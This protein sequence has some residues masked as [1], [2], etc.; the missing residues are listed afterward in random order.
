MVLNVVLGRQKSMREEALD[1]SE[2]SDV[3]H[4]SGMDLAVGRNSQR[5]T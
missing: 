4:V 1:E 3:S 2:Y 5:G